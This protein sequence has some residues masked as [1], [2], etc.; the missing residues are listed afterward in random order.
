MIRIIITFRLIRSSD[1]GD[2]G[3][4][5]VGVAA[6]EAKVHIVEPQGAAGE[7]EPGVAEDE[8][9]LKR[10]QRQQARQINT[11]HGRQLRV[12]AVTLYIAVRRSGV[13]LEGVAL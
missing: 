1:G 9:A 4:A 8:K 10:L 2:E 7:G 5:G 3:D 11:V 6:G 13:T 12:G